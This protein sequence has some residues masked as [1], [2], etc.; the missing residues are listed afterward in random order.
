MSRDWTPEELQAASDAMKKAGHMSYE[1]F[2]AELRRQ[3]HEHAA[4]K[5]Q[6]ATQR[7][8]LRPPVGRTRKG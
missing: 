8:L 4:E 7:P 3:A 6:I 1:E 5:S 2:C